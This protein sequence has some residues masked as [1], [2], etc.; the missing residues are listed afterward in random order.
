MMIINIYYNI[1]IIIPLIKLAMGIH[2]QEISAGLYLIWVG[3]GV[4][5]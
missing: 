3:F 4:Q 1:I 2:K 5:Y